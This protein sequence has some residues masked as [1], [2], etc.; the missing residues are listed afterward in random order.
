MKEDIKKQMLFKTMP[1]LQ[2]AVENKV[3]EQKL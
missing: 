1:S 3:E 2:K